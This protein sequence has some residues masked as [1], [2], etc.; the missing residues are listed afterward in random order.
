MVMTS[1]FAWF[2]DRRA[3]FMGEEIARR[4]IAERVM[5]MINTLVPSIYGVRCVF[6][7]V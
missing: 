4:R 7:I 5:V 3:R 1:L 6:A 2:M